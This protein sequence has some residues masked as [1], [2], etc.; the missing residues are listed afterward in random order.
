MIH[1]VLKKGMK[2]K[3]PKAIREQTWLKYI[4]QYYNSKCNIKWCK[5]NITVFDF[6]VGHNIPESKGGTLNITNLRPIC[7]RCNLSMSN[8]Y[9]IEEWNETQPEES[10]GI[11]CTWCWLKKIWKKRS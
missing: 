7:S 9:T 8:K 1:K 2:E 4:G 6:H 5:N 10:T 11:C 3:I